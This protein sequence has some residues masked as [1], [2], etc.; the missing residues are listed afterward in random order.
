MDAVRMEDSEWCWAAGLTD[1]LY[2]T[3]LVLFDFQGL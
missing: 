3:T 1:Q 2:K